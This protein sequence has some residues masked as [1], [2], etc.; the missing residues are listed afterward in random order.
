MVNTHKDAI[1]LRIALADLGQKKR[2]FR[3]KKILFESVKIA[4][5]ER[6]RIPLFCGWVAE[7]PRFLLPFRSSF[8]KFQPFPHFSF[9]LLHFQIRT[10]SKKPSAYLLGRSPQKVAPSRGVSKYA[11]ASDVPD[12]SGRCH[13]LFCALKTE[14]EFEIQSH[15]CFLCARAQNVD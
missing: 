4:N 11:C 7:N 1:L 9:H 15:F 2:Q 12:F 14:V 8:L 3:K 6:F 5:E 10:Y 13:S